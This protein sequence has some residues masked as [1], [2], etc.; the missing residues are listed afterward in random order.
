LHS[1][2]FSFWYYNKPLWET[3]LIVL[4]SGGSILSFVGV[5]IGFKRLRRAAGRAA[6]FRSS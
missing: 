2:D 3:G 1:L 6:G 5:V 4:L